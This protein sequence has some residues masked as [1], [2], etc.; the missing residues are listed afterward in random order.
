MTG[1]AAPW[2]MEMGQG[3]GF[4]ESTSRLVVGEIDGAIDRTGSCSLML[5]GGRTASELH[6][7]W[8]RTGML[9]GR[10]IGFGLG[11]ERLETPDSDA[12]NHARVVSDLFVGG[13]C[14]LE[15]MTRDLGTVSDD[16]LARQATERLPSRVDV[17][18]LAVGDDGH[19]ASLFPGSPALGAL[20]RRIIVARSPAPPHGRLTITPE[21]ISSAVEAFVMARGA[22]KGRILA[23]AVSSAGDV[24]S[25]P[26]LLTLGRPWLL[27][28]DACEAYRVGLRGRLEPD[29]A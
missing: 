24:R 1:S 22:A 3:P 6:D 5:T 20:G 28:D 23:E 27:D 2:I 13:D 14:P 19:V 11:D 21:V 25:F 29:R 17:L 8:A 7:H 26:V 16:E 12:S 9:A 15:P 4:L 10:D 18:L